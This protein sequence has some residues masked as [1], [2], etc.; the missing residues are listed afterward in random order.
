MGPREFVEKWLSKG[1]P[2]LIEGRLKTRKWEGR[3]G[4]ERWTTEIWVSDVQSLGRR[5]TG[6][7]E[8]PV[9]DPEPE[10]FEDGT[11]VL[12]MPGNGGW[13]H[14]VRR[15]VAGALVVAACVVSGCQALEA[16]RAGQGSGPEP[17]VAPA[18]PAAVVLGTTRLVRS[19]RM[20][21][22]DVEELDRRVR[23]RRPGG[24]RTAGGTTGR[25]ACAE[26]RD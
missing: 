14:M 4:V 2:V 23:V 8:P 18:A 21:P 12:M 26:R 11:A 25:S 17:E 10:Q 13:Q 7:A 16:R 24:D 19:K 15:G 22:A 9:E 1:D 3:D 20:L 6:G 5:G